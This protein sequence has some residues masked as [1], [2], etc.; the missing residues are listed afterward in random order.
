MIDSPAFSRTFSAAFASGRPYPP[1][2][3]AWLSLTSVFGLLLAVGPVQADRPKLGNDEQLQVNKAIDGG[4][5]YLLERQRIQNDGSFPGPGHPVGVT[6]LAGLALLECGVDPGEGTMRAAAKFVIDRWKTLDDTYDL[7]LAILFLDR[8]GE[9][10]YKPAIQA[11]ALRLIGGQTMTGGWSYKCPIF[12]K[13]DQDQLISVLRKLEKA[14]KEEAMKGIAAPKGGKEGRLTGVGAGGKGGEDKAPSGS[15]GSSDTALDK[16]RIPR[17]GTCIKAADDSLAPAA[18]ETKQPAGGGGAGAPAGRDGPGSNPAAKVNIV[19][20]IALLPVLQDFNRMGDR[21]PRGG[22]AD[23]PVADAKARTDNSNTQ[24]AILAMWTAQHHDVPTRRTLQLIVKRFRDSQGPDGGWVYGYSK[25]GTGDSTPA[26]TCSGLAGLAV[27]FGMAD[28]K[29]AANQ[30]DEQL[31]KRGFRCLMRFVGDPSDQWG[32]RVRLQENNNLYYL[33]SIERVAVMYNLPTLGAK[34]WYRW[35]AEILVSNQSQSLPHPGAWVEG[36]NTT[37]ADP[38]VNTSFALLFLRGANLTADLT[39]KLPIDPE[40]LNK[41]LAG[42]SS[43]PTLKTK[44]KPGAKEPNPLGDGE[45]EIERPIDIGQVPEKT[46]EKEKQAAPQVQAPPP[47]PSTPAATQKKADE[48]GN[49]TMIAIFAVV[50]VV[51]I[52]GVGAAIF[53]VTRKSKKADGDQDDEKPRRSLRGSRFARQ[54]DDDDEEKPEPRRA[55]PPAKRAGSKKPSRA[56]Y[57]DDDDD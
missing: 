55:P 32:K 8:L 43:G 27:G 53:L 21:N 11:F 29:K 1:R 45:R 50:A 26:M 3:A 35:G 31:V 57:D 14:E 49:G 44:P 18:P 24:F 51:V 7:S 12:T 17:P 41:E 28:A 48:G 22:P 20:D 56:R 39:P 2:V 4:V 30:A 5:K 34:D 47:A 36:G 52:A 25:P 42:L 23:A 19:G 13:R 33:W 37:L 10:K 46:E 38:V 16:F 54:E 9:S 15:S 6:A 40:E